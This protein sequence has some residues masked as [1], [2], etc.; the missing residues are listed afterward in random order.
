MKRSTAVQAI[1]G[2]LG[3]VA[4]A[5]AARAQFAVIDVAAINQLLQQV[6]T[7]VR[8]LQTAENQLTQAQLE[9]QSLTGSRGMQ[10]LLSGTNRNY[11]PTD[12]PSL[13]G[14]LTGTGGSYGPLAA[15]VQAS[16]SANAVLSAAQLSALSASELS[17]VQTQRQSVALLQ[18][19]SQ[20]ALV[21]SSGRFD[22][23]QQLITT[24]GS[25]TD[26]KAILDLH[27]RIS[28]EQGMLQA[29][30]TKLQVLY[31]TVLAQEAAEQQRS[32]EQAI[33]DAG[34]LRT[35]PAMGL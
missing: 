22:Q 24:I 25:A 14:T 34:S 9:Y 5:P 2:W 11:L 19:V 28:A 1:A 20:Q 32:R 15:S 18:G 35:L 30:Q 27:A 17:A 10:N 23:M 33:N 31:Q 21:N 7:A 16:M 3:L 6:Q 13:Q 12:T 8:Q 4:L 29:E 26:P